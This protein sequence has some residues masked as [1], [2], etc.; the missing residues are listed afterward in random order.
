ML[1]KLKQKT[2]KFS[3]EKCNAHE[4]KCNAH[5]AQLSYKQDLIRQAIESKTQCLIF[6]CSHGSSQWI[7][8]HWSV[9][10]WLEILLIIDHLN[11]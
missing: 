3:C 2:H 5:Q 4:K 11:S 6:V 8:E 1:K 7:I 9:G 10:R